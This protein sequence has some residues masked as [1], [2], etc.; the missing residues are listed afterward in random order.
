MK[1]I[2]ICI[3]IC[4]IHIVI[5]INGKYWNVNR[6]VARLDRLEVDADL[7]LLLSLSL[8]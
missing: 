6:N 1:I 5:I 4:D 8:L 7:I 2:Y 3:M